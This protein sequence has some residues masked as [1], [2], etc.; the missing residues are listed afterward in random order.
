[1]FTDVRCFSL[2]FATFL[3]FEL[4]TVPYVQ[5]EEKMIPA[6]MDIDNGEII[7]DIF[8]HLFES[9]NAT[10]IQTERSHSFF[11]ISRHALVPVCIFRAHLEES[12][13]RALE[14]SHLIHD[15]PNPKTSEG[16]TT[17]NKN[18]FQLLHVRDLVTT[19]PMA[20]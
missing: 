18:I 16:Y 3:H 11:L 13:A 9:Q 5:N 8:E 15:S 12:S 2:G 10:N 6:E 19:R 4:P 7:A 17:K 14:S 1:M 20:R